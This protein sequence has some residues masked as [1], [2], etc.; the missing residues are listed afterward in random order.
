[1][2][3]LREDPGGSTARVGPIL[4]CS[5]AGFA[6]GGPGA[7]SLRPAKARYLIPSASGGGGSLCKRI[8]PGLVFDLD[9]GEAG[10][11]LGGQT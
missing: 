4:R 8:W 9:S 2:M 10:K 11:K 6:L 7:E 3:G 1:L 5:Q